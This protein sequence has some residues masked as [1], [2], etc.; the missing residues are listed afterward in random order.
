MLNVEALSL[1][2]PVSSSIRMYLSGKELGNVSL[3]ILKK[4]EKSPKET[5][6]EMYQPN[7]LNEALFTKSAACK[8]LLSS[9]YWIV[10]FYLGSFVASLPFSYNFFFYI[11]VILFNH[12]QLQQTSKQDHHSLEENLR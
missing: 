2:L 7:H 1:L 5:N 9:Q 12:D 11:L 3:D 6:I 4:A 10:A 8:K